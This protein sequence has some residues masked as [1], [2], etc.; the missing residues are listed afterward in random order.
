[1]EYALTKTFCTC[2][3]LIVCFCI[4]HVAIAF[5]IYF[6]SCIH[7][8]N[9]TQERNEKRDICCLAIIKLFRKYAIFVSSKIHT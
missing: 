7:K 5:T 4:C 6:K 2:S 8:R 3:F 9:P 1:M